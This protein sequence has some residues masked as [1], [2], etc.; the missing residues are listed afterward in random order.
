MR[1]VVI[2]GMSGSGKSEAV[3]ALEDVGFFCVD[4]L[5]V[6]LLGRFVD[7]LAK[8]E[9]A[10]RVALVI[11]VRGG[12]YLA[13]CEAAF[14]EIRSADHTLEIVFFDTTDE[15]LIRR[16]SETRRRHPLNSEDLRAGLR[17]ER[18][19]LA[20]LRGEANQVVETST[21]TVHEL[22]RRLRQQYATR[23]SHLRV[24]LLSFGFKYGP[25]SEADLVFDVRFLPNP[26]FVEDLR[27]LSGIDSRVSSFVCEKPEFAEFLKRLLA[28]LELVLPLYRREGKAYLTVAIGCTGGRHRSVA[29]VEALRHRLEQEYPRLAVRH[30]DMERT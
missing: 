20:G 4:N 24:S 19:L 3:K 30:R 10:S 28:L 1:V 11:D 22:R 27:P 25:P 15:V 12:E 16:F 26:Y 23:D 2:T 6:P 21:V 13:G 18:E 7:L 5:P 17:Q 14:K 8:A 29:T 9:E